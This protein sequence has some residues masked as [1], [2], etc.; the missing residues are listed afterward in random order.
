VSAKI[1]NVLQPDS[2][3]GQ[4]G[5]EA[6]PQLPGRPVTRESGELDHR[7]EAAPDVRRI[8]SGT[9]HA[10]EDQARRMP[11]RTSLLAVF[12][13][14]FLM[15]VERI[16]TAFRQGEAPPR[17]LGFGVPA[18]PVGS[19]DIDRRWYRRSVY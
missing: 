10:R 19:P 14:P 1:G 17:L 6:V 9:D 2:T 15:I 8:K 5:D 3:I 4:Q 16:D 7:S 13:L 12:S 11:L 18:G